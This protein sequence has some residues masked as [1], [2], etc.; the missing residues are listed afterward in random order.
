M[1]ARD[2]GV[3]IWCVLKEWDVEMDF[4]Q[5]VEESSQL[6]PS[7]GDGDAQHETDTELP[8]CWKKKHGDMRLVT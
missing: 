5:S 4:E 7:L 2:E 8:L 1:P 6:T 3:V